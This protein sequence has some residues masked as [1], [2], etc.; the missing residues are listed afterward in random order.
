MVRHCI[1]YGCKSRSTK[2]E[3]KELSRHLLPLSNKELLRTWLIKIK[4]TS[5]PVGKN[6]YLCSQ[7]FEEECFIKPL[8]GQRCDECLFL[9]KNKVTAKVNDLLEQ[10]IIERV[11][12]FPAWV[13]PIVVG[14]K[15]SGDMCR[16]ARG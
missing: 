3:W 9:L 11:Q 5:T 4:R 15:A 14:P 7:H 12:G 13:S 10:D 1:A 2:E 6:F 8:G 16:Y